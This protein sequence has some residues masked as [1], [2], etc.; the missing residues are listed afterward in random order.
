MLAQFVVDGHHVL[1]GLVDQDFQAGIFL[2]LA[3]VEGNGREVVLVEVGRQGLKE[4][5]GALPLLLL[6]AVV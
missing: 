1:Q 4:H 2:A 6:R 5:L 3:E